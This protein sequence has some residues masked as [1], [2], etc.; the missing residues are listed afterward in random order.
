MHTKSYSNLKTKALLISLCCWQSMAIGPIQAR[1]EEGSLATPFLR[2]SLSSE[3]GRYELK[4]EQGGVT[5]R[6]N[7]YHARFGEV[8]FYAG[9]TRQRADL[10]HSTIQQTKNGLEATFQLSA[11]DPAAWLRVSIR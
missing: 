4:D 5:W 2:F 7:P 3:T 1:A 8:T 10:A 6:S 11:I 9:G